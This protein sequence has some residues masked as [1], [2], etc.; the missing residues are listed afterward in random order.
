[1]FSFQ[2]IPSEITERLQREE[3]YVVHLEG[4]Y[5]LEISLTEVWLMN[6]SMKWGAL[7]APEDV[8]KLLFTLIAREYLN[9]EKAN[10][11]KRWCF[12][13]PV[14]D[15]ESNTEHGYIP[16]RVVE[17]EPGYHLFAGR[18]PN[19]SPWYWGDLETAQKLA[20]EANAKMGL[21]MEDVAAIVM[22]SIAASREAGEIIE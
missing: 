18:D 10:R 8:Q 15:P 7:L 17:G 22:S 21:S 16:A 14:G 19:S 1:M 2:Q 3:S 4:G 11:D 12:Y 9:R 20:R 6:D 13:I 5:D